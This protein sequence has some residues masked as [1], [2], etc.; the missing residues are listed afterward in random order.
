MREFSRLSKVLP[1]G[2]CALALAACGKSQNQQTYIVPE[3]GPKID[4]KN[5]DA[6]STSLRLADA[7]YGKGEYAMAAQLYFRAAELQ[8]DAPTVAVKLGFALFKAGSPADA[9]K[10]FRA[11]L[12]KNAKNADALRG[13]G[14]SLV[15]QGR[16]AEALPFYRQAIAATAKPDPRIYAGLGAAL[17]MTG[18]HGEA[19]AAYQA[20]L[21]LAPQD[22]GLRNNLALSYAM[23]GD[24][25]KAQAILSGMTQNPATAPKAKQSL[26]TVNSVVANTARPAPKTR[27]R[28]VAEKRPVPKAAAATPPAATSAATPRPAEIREV[29]EVRAPVRAARA[30]PKSSADLPIADAGDG[31]VFIRTGRATV[32]QAD[33]RRK[34]AMSFK[35]SADTPEDAAAEVLELLAQAER[36]PRFIWQEARRPD[37]S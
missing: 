8:P 11:A 36:G 30:S 31:E 26:S 10:I 13:L 12:A 32:V 7:A 37:P 21:K 6:R 19:R 18:K 22:F 28:Q 29:A 14:H 17:D 34:P 24:T 3:D 35:S 1:A 15:T 9:E 20:G 33:A 4:A 5:L 23:S 16:A 27:P 25:E 2:L